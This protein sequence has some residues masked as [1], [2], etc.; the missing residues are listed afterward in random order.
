[1]TNKAEPRF[2]VAGNPE[3]FYAAGGKE[4]KDM[5]GWLAGQ[6]LDAYEYQC[7]RGAGVRETTARRVGEEAAHHGMAL[8]VHAP[9]YISLATE[10]AAIAANTQQHFL[11]SLQVARWLGADRVVFHIGGAG[12]GERRSA[13]T[14]ATRAFSRILE[15]G[16]Q[17]GLLDGIWLCPET[18]GKKNQLG[19][20]EEVLALCS[21][22][23]QRLRPA[24]DFGHL[25]AVSG[26]AYGT[27]REFAAVFE[28]VGEALGAEAAR[29]LHLH[30]SRIEFTGAGEK[31]HRT[32]ADPYGPPHEPLLE[33]C[34][35]GGYAPRIIC[36]S[37]GTQG[38]DAAAM[39]DCYRALLAGG[40]HAC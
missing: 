18:M 23:P 2:G 30:F 13:M 6:G 36:E 4:S 28:R 8:S 1:M 29:Q 25:H 33:C 39:R 10:D 17:L 9:Y 21:L 35:L 20:V 11:K 26:G 16:E 37:A 22:A 12:K 32:F 15:Q 7:S 27:W 40:C 31:R 5:P 3:A 24:V 14:R 19:T 38:L 34:V